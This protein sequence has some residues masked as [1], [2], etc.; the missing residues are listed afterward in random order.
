[1]KT[2]VPIIGMAYSCTRS[3]FSNEQRHPAQKRKRTVTMKKS[4]HCLDEKPLT[5][6]HCGMK[7]TVLWRRTSDRKSRICN[8]CGLHQ[9]QHGTLPKDCLPKKIRRRN[10]NR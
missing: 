2:A 1:M 3:N 8:P 9:R 6:V 10:R 4:K 7:E 5:C